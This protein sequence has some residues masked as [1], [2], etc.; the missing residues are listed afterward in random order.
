[1][2]AAFSMSLLGSIILCV[3]F[4]I[5]LDKM[6]EQNE[7]ELWLF[8][9]SLEASLRGLDENVVLREDT[10]WT[11]IRNIYE[12]ISYREYFCYN[13]YEYILDVERQ[14]QILQETTSM[15]QEA[16]WL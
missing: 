15:K 1:M 7:K 9:Y 14:N 6:M 11:I 10:L 8:R 5:N 4:R 13:E 12:N 3:T 16:H 2:L